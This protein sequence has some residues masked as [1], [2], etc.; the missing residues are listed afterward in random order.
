MNWYRQSVNIK[1]ALFLIGLVMVS[2]L[3]IYSQKIVTGLRDDNRAIV[4]I[5]AE[6]MANAVA[7]T[8]DENIN[9]IFESVIKNVSF[10]VIQSSPEGIPVSWRNLPRNLS[11]IEEVQSYMVKLDMEN[12]PIPLVVQL[13]NQPRTITIGYLHYGDSQMISQLNRLPYLEILAVGLFII[14]GFIGFNSIRNS[15]KRSIWVGMARETAHQLGTPLSALM[16][17]IDYLEEQPEKVK[18]IS[19]E[20]K[21]DLARLKQVNDRFSEMGSLKK[22]D[23]VDLQALLEET[24]KYIGSRVSGKGQNI[25]YS[26]EDQA[27][28]TVLGNGVLLSWAFENLLKNSLDA[29]SEKDGMVAIKHVIDRDYVNITIS[30]NGAGISRK[31]WKNIFRPGFSTKK[32]G[33]GLGLPL[34][35]RIFKEIHGGSLSII[36]ST[37]G[38]GTTFLVR[39]RFGI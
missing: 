36:E 38:K 5:Y 24:V 22:K 30:D 10:P 28:A 8:S 27:P 1:A 25:F 6:L 9:F 29:T 15:E 4:K 33:W 32:H 7:S 20:M 14:L 13:H 21:Q 23:S 37:P 39:L 31:D 16:G 17:W 11:E 2:G 26:P 35:K 34:T 3:I 18:N 19:A 12:A